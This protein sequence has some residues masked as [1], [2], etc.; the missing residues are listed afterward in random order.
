MSDTPSPLSRDQ[1]EGGRSPSHYGTSRARRN[2]PDY[3]RNSPSVPT[4]PP[5]TPERSSHRPWLHSRVPRASG[6]AGCGQ[7]V[8]VLGHPCD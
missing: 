2:A 6:I 1:E 8:R 3:G 5:S 7:L 4:R